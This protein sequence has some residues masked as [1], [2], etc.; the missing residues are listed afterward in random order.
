MWK[1]EQISVITQC[2]LLITNFFHLFSKNT[3]EMIIAFTEIN[4][5]HKNQHLNCLLFSSE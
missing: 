1:A 5:I 2:I 4:V 3:T